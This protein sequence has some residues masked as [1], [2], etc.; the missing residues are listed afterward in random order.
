MAQLNSDAVKTAIGTALAASATLQALIGN[1]IRLSH[2]V[3]RG[4]TFPFVRVEYQSMPY[5]TGYRR[6]PGIGWIDRMNIGFTA[7]A[8]ETSLTTVDN[9]KDAIYEVMKDAPALSV[10]NGAIGM[11]LPVGQW[12]YYNAED[13]TAVS[14]CEFILSVEDT[15]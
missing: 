14:H 9:I 12:S 10:T 13:G 11:S 15:T 8:K 3:D 2:F 4:T 1:P 5:L 7:F 6:A